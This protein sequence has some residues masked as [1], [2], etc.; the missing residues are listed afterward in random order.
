MSVLDRL[1][2]GFPHGLPAGYEQGCRGARECVNY[3][4]ELPLCRDAAIRYRSDYGYKKL[5]DQGMSP[6]EILEAERAAAEAVRPQVL[7]AR[8]ARA[9]DAER[10][11]LAAEEKERAKAERAA[12]RE[13]A[14]LD[15]AAERA[16]AKRSR[17]EQV[18]FERAARERE[19][20]EHEAELEQAR[21]AG[22]YYQALSAWEKAKAAHRE[23][24][25]AARASLRGARKE[26]S[27]AQE[28]LQECVGVV[29][30][31]EAAL[32][33][34]ET[35]VVPRKPR[36]VKEKPVRVPRVAK[37]KAERKP[38]AVAGPKHGS[39]YGWQRGCKTIEGCPEHAAGRLSCVEVNR[40]YHREYAAKRKAAGGGRLTDGQLVHGTASGYAAGC[41]KRSECPGGA[42]DGVK[43][44]D[45]S[46]AVERERRR[47]AGIGPAPEMVDAAP[48][49]ERVRSLMAG[50]EPLLAIAARADVSKTVLKNV[51][52]G[53]S[54][55]R[56]GER[57]SQVSAENAKKIL[58]LS[59]E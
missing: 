22:E 52:Y 12:A 48:V 19:A 50:G 33:E 23:G 40:E 26:L 42:L 30:D 35:A 31:A 29:A 13:Q 2:D 56:R 16:A 3:D 36:Q 54:G 44:A 57:S 4:T 58:A 6:A 8:H 53:R 59:A 46:L 10:V 51:V 14:R 5:V 9:V 7:A 18:E 34:A 39:M 47:R 11:R 43:C 55:D 38:R 45:A 15:R 32:A 49:L 17:A 41:R 20:A 21:A 1:V 24:V 25:K 27:A 37:E 28:R